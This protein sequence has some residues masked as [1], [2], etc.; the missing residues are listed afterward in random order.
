MLVIEYIYIV[1]W[2]AGVWFTRILKFSADPVDPIYSS[3]KKRNF[4]AIT[5][6]LRAKQTNYLQPEQAN[7][8]NFSINTLCRSFQCLR[9]P[10]LCPWS[11]ALC[12]LFRWRTIHETWWTDMRANVLVG[13]KRNVRLC[14]AARRLG[15][16]LFEH[17]HFWRMYR[18]ISHI[19]YCQRAHAQYSAV[20]FT[21]SDQCLVCLA[22]VRK[23]RSFFGTS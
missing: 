8:I 9:W 1:L 12:L 18:S 7:R 3:K 14:P 17:A 4:T 15:R 23:F 2:K 13:I 22:V 19:V 16:T 5:E 6:S 11:R 10:P 21:R 20:T